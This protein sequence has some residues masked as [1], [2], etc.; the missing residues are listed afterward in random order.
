MITLDAVVFDLDDTLY[1]ERAFAFSGF[2]A[3]A[4]A[5]PDIF[6]DPAQATAR[7]VQLFDTEHRR[8][9][10]NTVLTQSGVEPEEQLVSRMIE[11]YR[12][13]RPRIT[14]HLDAEAVLTRF[15]GNFQLGLITDGPAIMQRNK[16]AA[17]GLEPRF[18]KIILTDEL[19]EGCAKPHPRAFELMSQRLAVDPAR[20]VYVADNP[21]KDFLAP[22]ALGWKT[23]QIKRKDGIYRRESPPKAGRPDHLIDTLDALDVLLS[24]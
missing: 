8:R 14:L 22:S 16:I 18:D 7:M 2:D 20:C 10:F 23:I 11:T 12:T 1:P 6:S 5:L 15:A 24:W 3:V 21:A 9:V 19:G 17:L 13:H 4:E